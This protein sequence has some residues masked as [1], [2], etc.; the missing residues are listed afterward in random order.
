MHANYR[1]ISILCVLMT[2]KRYL[3]SIIRLRLNK[4]EYCLIHKASFKEAVEI[5]RDT[6]IFSEKDELKGISDNILFGKL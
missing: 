2:Q 5:L 4:N 6:G 3:T 1:H